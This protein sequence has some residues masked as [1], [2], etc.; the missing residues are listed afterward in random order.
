VDNIDPSL[1]TH[2]IYGFAVLDPTTYTIQVYDTWMD[3]DNQFYA[4]FNALKQRKAGLKTLIA[5]GGW[6]DSMSPKYSQ[7]VSDPNKIKTFVNSVLT[8]LQRY[9]FDG[10][11]VDW[12]YPATAA[13][14]AGLTQLLAALRSAFA[15]YGYLLALAVNVGQPTIDAGKNQFIYKLRIFSRRSILKLNDR[16][17]LQINIRCLQVTM[18]PMST[19]TPILS[20]SCLTTC[21]A[22]GR[23]SS[24]I[25][26]L[27]TNVHTTPLPCKLILASSTGSARAWN[28]RRSLWASLLTAARS[29]WP[30]LPWHRFHRPLDQAPADR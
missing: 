4:K 15:P 25:M 29:S 21:T 27:F 24:T 14:K 5:I 18:S 26:R 20:T 11:D 6:N 3:I 30:H 23:T 19:S 7:L 2:L 13:D 10:L 28:H 16:L 9:G 12:E 17:P 22:R 1:C 8:F